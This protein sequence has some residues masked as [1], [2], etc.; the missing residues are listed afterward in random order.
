MNGKTRPPQLITSLGGAVVS[1]TA[2]GT[3]GRVAGS[4]PVEFHRFGI[5]EPAGYGFLGS[6]A[7]RGTAEFLLVLRSR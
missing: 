7:D 3:A 4:L 2:V 5:T 6:L 1:L